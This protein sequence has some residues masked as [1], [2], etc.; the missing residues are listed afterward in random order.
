[1]ATVT[2]HRQKIWGLLGFWGLLVRAAI[3]CTPRGEA[4]PPELTAAR[5]PSVERIAFYR[6]AF[7]EAATFE[8]RPIPPEMLRSADQGNA[9]Y[10]VALDSNK[11]P[12][13]YLR[14]FIGPVSYSP[15]DCPCNPLQVT[16][17][18]DAAYQFRTLLTT[19]PLQKWG[20]QPLTAAEH[21]QM[22]ELVRNPPSA[23]LTLHRPDQVVDAT[24]GATKKAYQQMVVPTAGLTTH[25]LITLARDTARILQG[26][27]VAWEAKALRNILQNQD[28][29][30]ARLVEV[31]AGF[32]PT[33]QTPDVQ[34][35]TYRQ[36]AQA[37]S[38]HL[39]AGEALFPEAQ[40]LLLEPPLTPALKHAERLAACYRI[41]LLPTVGAASVAARCVQVVDRDPPPS[42]LSP[43]LQRLAGSVA[44]LQ[45]RWNVA[46]ENLRGAAET[47]GMRNAPF[48]HLRLARALAPDAPE[49]GCIQ[50]E[51][52]F[53]LHPLLPGARDA[54]EVCGGTAAEQEARVDRLYREIRAELLA[55]RRRGGATL[56][57]LELENEARA[58]VDLKMAGSDRVSVVF[59]FATW[60]PHCQRELPKINTFY[61][62]LQKRPELNS[63]VRLV[64]VRTALE[65]ETEPYEVF[66]Q[67]YKPAFPVLI[68]PV[69]AL[70]FNKFARGVG[71]PP[72]LP[73]VAVV[74]KSGVVRYVLE[75]GD[76]RDVK[77]ELV[78][79]LEDVVKPA[80]V[81]LHENKGE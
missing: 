62:V 57:G 41:S 19:T 40:R 20:H 52:V 30:R 16:L 71:M 69:M 50:A 66:T 46:V 15:E 29:D 18:F 28:Q 7:A 32:L 10:V 79:A 17:V 75:H 21:I 14:D 74:D 53:A 60:C 12:M 76:F 72:S 22:V 59:F 26:A 68:D 78:W 65:R 55:G 73:L 67:R 61:R 49:E 54:L 36:L 24:S 39:E 3:A 4:P 25:R 6:Q 31:L 13:G 48:L 1:M 47:F 77:Q 51:R 33:A 42:E 45:G 9:A 37:S 58:T 81:S 80:P 70:A 34:V 8:R 38:A 23:L 44:F 27:P 11:T 2:H 64:A 63:Q 5:P 43:A 35:A 56:P